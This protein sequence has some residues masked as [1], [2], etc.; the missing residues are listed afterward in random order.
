MFRGLQERVPFKL[1]QNRKYIREQLGYVGRKGILIVTEMPKKK[2]KID[3]E[4]L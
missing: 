1:H 3:Y 4:V 2:T